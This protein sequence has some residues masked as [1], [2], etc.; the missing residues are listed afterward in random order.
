LVIH[1]RGGPT[2]GAILRPLS[3][4]AVVVELSPGIEIDPYL[5]WGVSIILFDT[6]EELADDDLREI[7][8]VVY[9]DEDNPPK[10]DPEAHNEVDPHLSIAYDPATE[11]YCCEPVTLDRDDLGSIAAPTLDEAIARSIDGLYTALAET[12]GR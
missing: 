12:A 3:T 8:A 4:A 6:A 2:H 11:H 1:K 9:A 10:Y 7:F 5:F